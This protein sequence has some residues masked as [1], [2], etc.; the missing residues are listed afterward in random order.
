MLLLT[1]SSSCAYGF[2]DMSPGLIG[3][4]IYGKYGLLKAGM[5]C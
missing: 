1:L 3:F 2:G 5:L 4:V